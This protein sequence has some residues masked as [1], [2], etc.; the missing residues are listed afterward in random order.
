MYFEGYFFNIDLVLK[1]I[2]A[3]LV[4]FYFIYSR[5]KIKSISPLEADKTEYRRV[6]SVKNMRLQSLYQSISYRIEDSNVI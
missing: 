5:R 4:I 6:P 2:S 1:V 3:L